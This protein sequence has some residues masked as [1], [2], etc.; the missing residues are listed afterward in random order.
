MEPIAILLD[1]V[2]AGPAQSPRE[3]PGILL[4]EEQIGQANIDQ[5]LVELQLRKQSAELSNDS[6]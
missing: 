1:E 5:F 4:D 3:T 6:N 2:Q